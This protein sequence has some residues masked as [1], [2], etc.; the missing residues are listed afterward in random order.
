MNNLIEAI[1]KARPELAETSLLSYYNQLKKLHKEVVSNQYEIDGFEFLN[2]EFQDILSYVEQ[3]KSL[4]RRNI[5]NAVIVAYKTLPESEQDKEVLDKY[6]DIRDIENTEY[7]EWAEKNEKSEK[8]EKNWITVKEV[9]TIRDTFNNKA[10]YAKYVFLQLFLEYPTR[11]DYRSLRVITHR[12]LMT[13]QKLEQTRPENAP[14]IAKQNYFVKYAKHNYYIVLNQ[15]KTSKKYQKLN[16]QLKPEFSKML[17][18]YLRMIHGQ[19]YLFT[20]PATGV[21]YTTGEFTK[22]IQSMFAGT[23]KSI[24][25]TLLRHVV[26]SERF[27]EYMKQTAETA[28]IMGHSQS[29]QQLYVKY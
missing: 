10:E 3:K 23:N 1:R 27:G 9:E 29:M 18:R 13:L 15:F 2:T 7:A 12:Q 24:S 19:P 4:C 16:I 11:N 21:G 8:Q 22:W 20:N 14:P 17:R 26:V 25:S 5:L 28:R 6:I